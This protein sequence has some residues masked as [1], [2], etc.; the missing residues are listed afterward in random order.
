MLIN[1]N[2]KFEYFVFKVVDQKIEGFAK[3]KLIM[4]VIP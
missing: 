2:T 3:K 4:I 1:L